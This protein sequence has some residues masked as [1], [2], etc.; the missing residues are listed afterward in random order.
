MTEEATESEVI[1]K[2]LSVN[3]STGA[4]S[5]RIAQNVSCVNSFRLSTPLR[6]VAALALHHQSDRSLADLR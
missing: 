5:S 4:H 6:P 2:Y 1:L 3:E